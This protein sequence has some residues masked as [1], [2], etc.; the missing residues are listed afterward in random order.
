MIQWT[1][2]YLRALT[3]ADRP[4]LFGHCLKCLIKFSQPSTKQL[5]F[6]FHFMVY[7]VELS[8]CLPDP[9]Q[10]SDTWWIELFFIT[11]FI[12]VKRLVYLHFIMSS[13]WCNHLPVTCLYSDLDKCCVLYLVCVISSVV[14]A[15]CLISGW[16]WSRIGIRYHF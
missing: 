11:V 13:I 3:Y 14:N 12:Q 5:H 6:H 1:M 8:H 9:S 4:I 10:W 2:Q 7:R 16:D 15:D